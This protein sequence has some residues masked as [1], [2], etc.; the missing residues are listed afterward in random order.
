MEGRTDPDYGMRR[1]QL[2]CHGGRKPGLYISRRRG[3]F[4]AQYEHVVRSILGSDLIYGFCYTQLS[5]VEQE[6]NGLLTASSNHHPK[7]NSSLFPLLRRDFSPM[8]LCHRPGNGKP[9]SEA[10]RVG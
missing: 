5:G 1:H 9:D 4:P 10:A 2:Q 8:R 7:K 6:S 3:G